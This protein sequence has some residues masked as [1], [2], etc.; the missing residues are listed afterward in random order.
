M[1]LQPIVDRLAGKPFARVEGALEFAELAK[2]PGALPAA[3]VVP[4]RKAAADNKNGTGSIDQRVVE[5]FMVVLVM[6]PRARTLN[7]IDEQMAELEDLAI[8][9]LLGFTPPGHSTPITY[10][11]GDLAGVGPSQVSWASRFRTAHHLR[12][13]S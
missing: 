7:K 13:T 5:E 10:G 12:K 3:F 8:E 6:E 9:R 2:R 11:G 4:V 1:R